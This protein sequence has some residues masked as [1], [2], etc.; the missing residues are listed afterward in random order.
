MIICRI[1]CAELEHFITRITQSGINIYK[2]KF[3]NELTATITIRKKDHHRATAIARQCGAEVY[4]AGRRDIVHQYKTFLA[5]PVLML[6][7]MFWFGLVIFLPTRVLFIKVIGCETTH[8]KQIIEAAEACG[9]YFGASRRELHSEKIKNALLSKVPQLSWVG[10]NTYGCVAEIT[11]QEKVME[12]KREPSAAVSSLI[13]VRDGVICDIAVQKGNLLCQLGQVVS[14]GE[15]LVS[16]YTDCG[17]TTRAERAVGKIY[18]HTKRKV[19]AISPIVNETRTEVSGKKHK[20]FLK[21]GKNIIN[22]FNSSGISDSGCAKIYREKS[23]RLPG[24]FQLPISLICETE[25]SYKTDADVA[26]KTTDMAVLSQLYILTQLIDGQIVRDSY[27]LTSTEELL[28]LMGIYY[29]KEM[30]A[31]ERTEEMPIWEK[32]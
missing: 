27:T 5:R 17:L 22:L 8:Q 18:A 7:L 31:S 16:G 20:I 2:L 24:G 32:K 9:I 29:C 3:I 25:I 6:G 10:V 11:V 1:F 26:K 13:A 14:K 28:Q 19:T 15:L 21:I 23:V 30:I 4:I 12:E